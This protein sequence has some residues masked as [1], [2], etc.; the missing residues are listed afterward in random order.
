MI[1]S[2]KK[3][4]KD[5]SLKTYQRGG[6]KRVQLLRELYDLKIFTA[7][8]LEW[9]FHKSPSSSPLFR[10]SNLRKNYVSIKEKFFSR[11]K[12]FVGGRFKEKDKRER[13]EERKE[14][15]KE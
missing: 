10:F 6:G 3:K 8:F 4:R 2:R 14:I 15:M 9:L 13:G 1:F 11:R 5:S 7:F 12:E